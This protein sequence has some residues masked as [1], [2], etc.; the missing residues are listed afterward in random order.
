MAGDWVTAIDGQV[1]RTPAELSA[2]VRDRGVGARVGLAL[3][4][5]GQPRLLAAKLQARPDPD[6]LL[7]REFVGRPAPVFGP[8]VTGS[9]PAAVTLGAYR[10]KVIVLEFWAPWCSACRLLAPVLS[11]WHERIGSRGGMVL[12]ISSDSRE[13]TSDGVQE[14]GIGYPVLVDED[15]TTTARYRAFALPTLFV[16]DGQGFVRQVLVGY[17]VEGLTSILLEVEA[18]LPSQHPAR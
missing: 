4:R 2:I 10:G 7:R 12:G 6:D 14:L 1:V 9:G 11:A 15:G 16:I 3:Q 13:A 5:Q 8:L 17:D 18:M